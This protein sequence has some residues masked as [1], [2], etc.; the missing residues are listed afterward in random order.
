VK[1]QEEK[2]TRTFYAHNYEHLEDE[3]TKLDLLIQQQVIVSRQEMRE[4]AVSQQVH[5]SPQ[6]VDWL[7]GQDGSPETE[8]PELAEVRNKLETLQEEINTR[9]KESLERGVFLALPQL[10][11]LFALSSFELQMVII[12]LAPELQCKYAKLYA[13]LQRDITRKKPS[14]NLALNLLCLTQEE[15][16][17]ARTYFLSQAALFKG[18]ILQVVEDPRSPR[19]FLLSRVLELDDRIV[20]FLLGAQTLDERIESF[21]ELVYPQV[22]LGE[23]SLPIELKTRLLSL[24]WNHL[25][26]S[27]ERSSRLI[28][29]LHGP[30]GSG[31]QSLA[32]AICRELGTPLV[33]SDLEELSNGERHFE[34]TL[35]LVFRE[36]LLQPAPIYLKGFHCLLDEEGKHLSQLRILA[37]T[38]KEFSWLT[39][40]AGERTWEPAG[41]FDHNTVLTVELPIPDYT[42][43]SELWKA[44]IDGEYQL[45]QQVDLEELAVKF[46]FTSGQIRDALVAAQNLARLRKPDEPEIMMQDLYRGCRAQC[47]QKLGRLAQK[48]VPRYT[49]E[50]I[51][52]PGDVLQQLYAICDQVK[53][54]YLVYGE[55]GFDRKLSLGKGLNALFSGPSG[56]GKTMAA[57]I[58][59]NE[60][61]LDLYKIDL[62]SVVSKYIGETEKNLSK[63]FGEA[64]SSNAILFFD[65]ADALFGKRSEVKDAHDRYANIEVG[66]LLQKMEEYEGIAVLATNLKR[67]M[68]E[69]FLRRLHFVI[70]FP[71]PDENH[72]YQIWRRIFPPEVPTGDDIDFHFLARRLNMSGGSIK[73]VAVNA[74]FLAASNSR[75]LTM[76]HLIAAANR[77]LARTG[78][79]SVDLDREAHTSKAEV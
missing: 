41:L 74:A 50:D 5:I 25:G 60:L 68:D 34:D 42:A 19:P 48:I 53:Y 67:N 30:Y 76:E 31:K 69:G 26:K 49:W 66:Y 8:Q 79:L 13:Y 61:Q 18:R 36:A 6:E 73:N 44:K 63:I 16:L 35:R 22:S 10:A 33:V 43:R 32:E 78:G 3:L 56:T 52:L 57:E 17:A 24:S 29:Y 28:Y 58:L 77:E 14:V 9:V 70:E 40:L 45:S 71:F 37:R 38:I 55:W 7:L 39:L 54:R 72:R 64:E 4:A 15:M 46:R 65:E 12:C 75:I 2:K 20:Y 62:S 21:S 27:N 1:I 51:V 47:N 11:H 23:V 59:V